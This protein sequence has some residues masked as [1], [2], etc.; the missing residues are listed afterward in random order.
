MGMRTRGQTLMTDRRTSLSEDIAVHHDVKPN[1][2]TYS[3]IHKGKLGP[4]FSPVSC[5]AT[6][7]IS[8]SIPYT[9]KPER[10]RQSLKISVRRSNQFN[11]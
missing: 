7:T 6:I 3:Y 9:P 4:P 8:E 1:I 10:R 2:T 5:V 11:F